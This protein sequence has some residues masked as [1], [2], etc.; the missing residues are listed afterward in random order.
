MDAAC[1]VL[2]FDGTIL[3]TE[4]PIYRSWSELWAEHG[5]ELAL[6]DWQRTIGT[7]GVFD[8]WNQLEQRLGRPLDPALHDRRRSRR[9]ELQRRH[10]PRPGIIGWLDEADALGIPVGIASSSPAHWVEGHLERLGLR[11]RFECLVCCDDEVPPKPDPTSY[12]LCSR[13]AGSG[14]G[15]VR[16][17]R[18]LRARRCRR[19]GGGAL[20]G[21]VSP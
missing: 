3:D 9:D 17:G 8:P 2:D 15:R 18:G 12:R 6:S 16:G 13:G 14:A 4:E 11:A 21:G 1:L 5:E 20:H 10:Q 19:G 7:D